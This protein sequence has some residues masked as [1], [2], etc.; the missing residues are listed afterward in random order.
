M[1]PVNWNGLLSLKNGLQRFATTLNCC[2]CFC[3]SSCCVCVCV[4]VQIDSSEAKE[5]TVVKLFAADDARMFVR[6][7]KEVSARECCFFR[8]ID[9]CI[10]TF[11]V[12]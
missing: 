4:C 5:K 9:F 2:C 1:S 7:D 11:C 10:V 3:Y 8:M 6:D 12:V